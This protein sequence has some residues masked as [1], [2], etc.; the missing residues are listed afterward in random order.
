MERMSELSD[1]RL[2]SDIILSLI[3]HFTSVL[4]H[5]FLR[6]WLLTRNDPQY[7][8]ENIGENYPDFE[9]NLK[10]SLISNQISKQYDIKVEPQEIVEEAKNRLR[11]QFRMYS[12]EL[13]GED[14][15]NEYSMKLL[16]NREQVNMLY[17]EVRALKVLNFLKSRL[18][19]NFTE[20]GNEDFLKLN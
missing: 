4:P 14:E 6:K 15:L 19:L 8:E 7:T 13:I 16:Q 1:K 17:E 12:Q 2:N 20:I 18:T 10:W 3:R 9:R 5:Q 11:I